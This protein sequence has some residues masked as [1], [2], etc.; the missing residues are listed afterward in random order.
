ME[1]K[2]AVVVFSSGQDS[3]TILLSL[4]E[5]PKFTDLH[6]LT[7]YYGQKHSVEVE[8]SIAIIEDLRNKYPRKHLTHKIIDLTETMKL[9]PANYLMDSAGE[10]IVIDEGLPNT[11]VPGRN[12]LF[13]TLA[14]SYA[15]SLESDLVYTGISQADFSN[16][17]DCTQEFLTNF[18]ETIRIGMDYDVKVIAPYMQLN[19][20]EIWE[21]AYY[22]GKLGYVRH[23][24]VT[25]YEGIKGD[26]CGECPACKLRQ[27]GLDQ[28]N[29]IF[30][31]K[32]GG[33]RK[34]VKLMY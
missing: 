13:F 26:G 34:C 17:P 2:S 12:I 25:C 22:L 5:D 10:G 28:F 9:T 27:K 15:Y 31:I 20:K 29:F 16:Y 18:N 1:K 24:T 32:Q 21:E 3:T 6:A 4:L 8:N 11:Y 23:N 33:K 14:A 19:K 30:P 7:Y